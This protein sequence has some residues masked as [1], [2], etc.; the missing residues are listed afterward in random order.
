[1]LEWADFRQKII[2]TQ[3]A[4]ASIYSTGGSCGRSSF[5][6]P[7]SQYL[8]YD[9]EFGKIA[10]SEKDSC[11]FD[12]SCSPTQI[13]VGIFSTSNSAHTS[14]YSGN[15]EGGRLENAL[16]YGL[17]ADEYGVVYLHAPGGQCWSSNTTVRCGPGGHPAGSACEPCP[18]SS[19]SATMGT[20]QCEPC[21]GGSAPSTN[22]TECLCPGGHS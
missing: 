18:G 6:R 3:V 4:A 5:K 8:C 21:T 16:Q 10:S 11:E 19:I 22:K 7:S 9:C 15:S 1:M 13:T 20:E 17:T 14:A 12:A 2:R